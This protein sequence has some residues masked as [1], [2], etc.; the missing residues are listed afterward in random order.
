MKYFVFILLLISSVTYGQ[1]TYYIRADTIVFQKVGGNTTFKIENATRTKTNAFLRNYNGGRTDFAY[2]IDTIWKINDSMFVFRRGDGNDTLTIPGSGGGSTPTWQQTLTAGSTLNQANTIDQAGFDLTFK[3]GGGGGFNVFEDADSTAGVGFMISSNG[4]SFIRSPF[5][6]T[7]HITSTDTTNFKPLAINPSTNEIKRLTTWPITTTPISSLTAATGTNSIDNGDFTQRWDWNTL[8]GIGMRL[9]SASTTASG[10]NQ[11]LFNIAM[12]G[13]NANSG[14]ETAA[15][16]ITNSHTGT[17]SINTGLRV[18]AT[19]GG[20]NY[21]ILVP[22]GGGSV[23]I[24]TSTPTEKLEVV[25]NAKVSGTGNYFQGRWRARVDS[26]TSSATPTIN[27]DNV[28]IFKITALAANITSMT[29]NLSGTPQDGDILE[30]QITGTAART[31]TWGAS[32]VSTTVTLPATT[33]TTATLT[34]ILQ[35]YKSGSY[36]NNLWYCVNSY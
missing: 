8:T 1:S 30:L 27:T 29:S 10:D 3:K 31:I 4:I 13:A 16:V 25:G 15:A 22:S 6:W 34:V 5:Y 14:E 7:N 18:S 33:V 35:Y 32:F 17:G 28:D 12:S 26:I 23:G 9:V 20:T 2:A 21:A 36:G 24:G 19:S 11:N